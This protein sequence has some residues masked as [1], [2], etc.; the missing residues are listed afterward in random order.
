MKTSKIFNRVKTV[1]VVVE[2]DNGETTNLDLNQET[3]L[4]APGLDS[5]QTVSSVM[6]LHV[7]GAIEKW[8]EANPIENKLHRDVKAGLVSV[9]KYTYPKNEN[10]KTFIELY[11]KGT[12][13]QTIYEYTDYVEASD[14]LKYVRKYLQK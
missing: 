14:D 12:W 10:G 13:A 9:D 8:V 3:L 11:V 2:F 5:I 1:K 6:G 7:G 4:S